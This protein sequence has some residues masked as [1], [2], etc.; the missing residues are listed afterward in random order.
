MLAPAGMA[1]LL[2]LL[3]LRQNYCGLGKILKKHDKVSGYLTK[4]KFMQRLV[5]PQAFTHTIRLQRMLRGSERCYSMLVAA[6]SASGLSHEGITGQDAAALADLQATNEAVVRQRSLEDE[7][8]SASDADVPS[9][10]RDSSA[11]AFAASSTQQFKGP[12]Q[13]STATAADLES[14]KRRRQ[15]EDTTLALDS[16]T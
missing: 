10:G 11:D 5:H 14:R 2:A 13:S 12:V 7:P 9:A 4:H 15:A 6:L 1:L 16:E 3:A 8:E